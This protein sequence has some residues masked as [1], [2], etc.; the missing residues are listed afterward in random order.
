MWGSKVWSK[1]KWY[2]NSYFLFDPK[3]SVIR[4]SNFEIRQE[5]LRHLFPLN[6]QQI[7]EDD[8]VRS[9]NRFHVN[10]ST[11][12]E[13]KDFVSTEIMM[14]AP[15]ETLSKR[16]KN[17]RLNYSEKLYIYREFKS[18]RKIKEEILFNTSI[19]SSTFSRIIKTF[20]RSLKY[21]AD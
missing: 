5:L 20:E 16:S 6:F 21:I 4:K 14:P 12:W 18:K 13:D 17:Q 7:E 3:A 10:E 15:N 1:S 11:Q 9:L 2:S 19:S 8:L